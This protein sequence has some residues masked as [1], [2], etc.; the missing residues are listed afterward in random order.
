LSGQSSSLNSELNM[1]HAVQSNFNVWPT[2]LSSYKMT[3]SM[4]M[5]HWNY[6][7]VDH[8]IRKE[9]EQGYA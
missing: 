4:I 5:T 8:L 2:S 7:F 1:N 6:M 3:I 9:T